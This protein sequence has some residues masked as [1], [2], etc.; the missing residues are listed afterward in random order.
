VVSGRGGTYDGVAQGSIHIRGAAARA[1][2][3]RDC[4]RHRPLSP[5]VAMTQEVL[6]MF[7][8]SGGLQSK[9]K[10]RYIPNRIL[11]LRC[12]FLQELRTPLSDSFHEWGI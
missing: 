11:R 7:A 12:A 3:D 6:A 10:N 2:P 4:S 1:H 9:L 5:K 8:R